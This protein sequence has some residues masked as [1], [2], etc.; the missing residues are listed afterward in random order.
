MSYNHKIPQC[1]YEFSTP[2]LRRGASERDFETPDAE[3]ETRLLE[4]FRPHARRLAYYREGFEGRTW[5]VTDAFWAAGLPAHVGER[6][7][8]T[9][10]GIWRETDGEK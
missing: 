5:E 8:V 1:R 6:A 10:E 9:P 7:R 4:L 2:D 3:E